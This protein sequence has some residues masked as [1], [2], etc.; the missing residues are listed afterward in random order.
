MRADRQQALV[1]FIAI[2]A[3][4]CN[5]TGSLGHAKSLWRKGEPEALEKARLASAN[6]SPEK[7]VEAAHLVYQISLE[8][9]HPNQALSDY[10]VYYRRL[11]R[12]DFKSLR[13]VARLI[14]VD[15]LNSWS[16]ERRCRAVKLAASLKYDRFVQAFLKRSVKN[17][18][19]QVRATAISH[20]SRSPRPFFQLVTDYVEYDSDPMVRWAR[21]RALGDRLKRER[22][23]DAGEIKRRFALALMTD[24]SPKVR[25]E[26][27]HQLADNGETEARL[28]PLWPHLESA[29]K[30][31]L[32]H[33]ISSSGEED[34]WQVIERDYPSD[35]LFRSIFGLD[36]G[37]RHNLVHL[38]MLG[39]MAAA[40]S[41]RA[42]KLLDSALLNE[43]D[44]SILIPSMEAAE[45][46]ASKSLQAS[47]ESLTRNTDPEVRSA[48]LSALCKIDAVLGQQLALR[49]FTSD[50][51]LLV[52]SSAFASYNRLKHLSPE[53]L[54]EW[55]AR[56]PVALSAVGCEILEK[57]GSAGVSAI[58][59]L[60]RESSSELR[61]RA[62]ES[63]GRLGGAVA[64]GALINAFAQGDRTM[65]R[66]VLRHIQSLN[67]R[68]FR[69]DY[70]LLLRN[71][72][73]SLN[74]E[75]AAALLSLS[76]RSKSR[77][78]GNRP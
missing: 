15:A 63:L 17:P 13:A 50:S 77:S 22:S 26:A 21:I 61:S 3:V 53:K 55:I 62:V 10:E 44:P 34:I 4:A 74:L 23:V 40:G 52:R 31:Q 35:Y 42:L 41:A 18:Q 9:G 46:C 49:F 47:I 1:L 78:P 66:R 11:G 72:A 25:M 51:D 71:Q 43:R 30:L 60:L 48:A 59:A 65:K 75:A 36:E 45:L 57:R 39:P 5:S 27:L 64:R 6:A 7:S 28:R 32:A 73:Q 8:G 38:K 70:F 54:R 67:I 68:H 69:S 12:H 19:G 33:R 16:L 2:T 24:S 37:S 76:Q 20:I 56:D 14:F 58:H 29:L